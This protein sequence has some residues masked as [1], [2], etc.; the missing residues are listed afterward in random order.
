[1]KEHPYRNKKLKGVQYVND[2]DSK[3]GYASYSERPVCRT[4][5]DVPASR[6]AHTFHQLPELSPELGGLPRSR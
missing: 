3:R 2:V 5:F 6:P 4:S 1:M